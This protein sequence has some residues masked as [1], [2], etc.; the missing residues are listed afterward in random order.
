LITQEQVANSRSSALRNQKNSPLLRLPGE[1]RNKIYEYAYGG[2][3][4]KIT[5]H[6]SNDSVYEQ[7]SWDLLPFSAA[8][9]FKSTMVCHQIH[10]EIGLIP[11]LHNEPWF[12]VNTMSAKLSMIAPAQRNKIKAIWVYVRGLGRLTSIESKP[13]VIEHLDGLELV[14]MVKSSTHLMEFLLWDAPDLMP[15]MLESCMAKKVQFKGSWII[16]PKSVEM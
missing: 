16:V 15:I 7:E 5:D 3:I 9:I 1:I 8:D 12:E 11:L 13:G 14:N 2:I 10:N 4:F 6:L